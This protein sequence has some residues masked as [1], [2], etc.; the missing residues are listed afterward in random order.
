[1]TSRNREKA[2]G[3][4]LQPLPRIGG[5]RLTS[6]AGS[7][8]RSPADS[9][10]HWWFSREKRW[11]TGLT[12]K[13]MFLSIIAGAISIAGTGYVLF[14]ILVPVSMGYTVMFR[15]DIFVPFEIILGLAGMVLVVVW[16]IDY[17]TLASRVVEE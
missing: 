16:L 1:M 10:R 11:K 3:A 12:T 17:L 6:Q 7:S 4:Q 13:R 5:K 14:S 2:R 8:R 15:T 9:M